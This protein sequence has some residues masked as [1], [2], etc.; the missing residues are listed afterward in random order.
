MT[1]YYIEPRTIKCV[2]GYGF[3]SL[4]RILSN[5]YGEKLLD[6]TNKSRTRYS[7]TTSKNLVHKTA[8]ATGEFI[9]NKIADEIAKP[10]AMSDMNLRNVE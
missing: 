6:T 2:K 8:K 5:K 3:L 10:K 1:C 9:E 4:A 7:K